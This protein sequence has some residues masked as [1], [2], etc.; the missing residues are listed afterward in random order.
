MRRVLQTLAL[1][2]GA[3]D[4]TDATAPLEL[5]G[6]AGSRLVA[7]YFEVE[8]FAPGPSASLYFERDGQ[9]RASGTAYELGPR[10][11]S[12]ELL[13]AERIIDGG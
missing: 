6:T 11:R 9:C 8:I 4:C 10:L 3:S 12:G 1:C 5:R 2:L 7:E 13:T